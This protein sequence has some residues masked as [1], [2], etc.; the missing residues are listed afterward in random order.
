VNVGGALQN[1][2]AP[3]FSATPPARPRPPV[4]D[5]TDLDSLLHHWKLEQTAIEQV[6]AGDCSDQGDNQ[7]KR[8]SSPLP[9]EDLL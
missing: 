3:R 1:A 8:H 5:R 6:L 7:I 4:K 2:P 9:I